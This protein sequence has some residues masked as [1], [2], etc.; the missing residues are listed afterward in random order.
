MLNVFFHVVNSGLY[1]VYAL[2]LIE[3][4]VAMAG[5]VTDAT[6]ILSEIAQGCQVVV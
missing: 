3:G 4:V 5:I 2:V 6:T 1:Y